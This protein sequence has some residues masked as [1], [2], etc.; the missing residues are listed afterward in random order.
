VLCRAL[1]DSDRRSKAPHGK[2]KLCFDLIFILE[3]VQGFLKLEKSKNIW[4]KSC[5]RFLLVLIIC[6]TYFHSECSNFIVLKK[7]LP[8]FDLLHPYK[9]DALFFQKHLPMIRFLKVNLLELLPNGSY[10]S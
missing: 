9:S 3:F 8:E 10:E 4:K 6:D 7:L 1:Q 5:L 2:E